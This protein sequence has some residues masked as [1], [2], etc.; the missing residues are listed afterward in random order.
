[1]GIVET[2]LY[3]VVAHRG[4][5]VCQF[6]LCVI[7]ALAIAQHILREGC[8]INGLKAF[9]SIGVAFKAELHTIRQVTR[10]VYLC[11]SVSEN[12]EQVVLSVVQFKD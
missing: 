9:V 5:V 4:S 12:I 6:R 7:L 10:K 8:R 1:M 3:E 11:K 2:L